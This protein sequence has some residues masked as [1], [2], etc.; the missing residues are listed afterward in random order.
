VCRSGRFVERGNSIDN[1][2]FESVNQYGCGNSDVFKMGD[3]ADC[4]ACKE[5][6]TTSWEDVPF[7]LIERTP[8]NDAHIEIPIMET[9]L[10]PAPNGDDFEYQLS[11]VMHAG[12][13]CWGN[14]PT[15]YCTWCGM[16]NACCKKGR[17]EDPS[18]CRSS[19]DFKTDHHECVAVADPRP[20]EVEE[21][22]AWSLLSIKT[23]FL[24][25]SVTL[26][27]MLFSRKSERVRKISKVWPESP[28]YS[29]SPDGLP[30]I[31][32]KRNISYL[33]EFVA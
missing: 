30:R 15:G 17:L 23:L 13:E 6:S 3:T 21:S 28:T 8:S 24:M 9:R 27:L 22:K 31:R 33:D 4:T 19:R 2:C 26:C 1:V 18:E 5:F 32:S 10:Q 29:K 16:G 12:E 20:P 11:P 7:P 25:V 14:C